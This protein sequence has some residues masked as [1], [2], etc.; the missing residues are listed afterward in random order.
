MILRN[1]SKRKPSNQ[2]Q[3]PR[4]RCHR[5]R[6][7]AVNVPNVPSSSMKTL[8]LTFLVAGLTPTSLPTAHAA[9]TIISNSDRQLASKPAAFGMEFEYGLQYVA[10]LQV[11]EE[12]LHLCHGIRDVEDVDGDGG[13]GGGYYYGYDE[14]G[15]KNSRLDGVNYLNL[16]LNL[17]LESNPDGG[18]DYVEGGEPEQRQQAER[19]SVSMEWNVLDGD[20]DNRGYAHSANRTNGDDNKN[21]DNQIYHH[22]GG[23]GILDKLHSL[24]EKIS[25]FPLGR[26]LYISILKRG[27]PRIVQL[28]LHTL[29]GNH[30]SERSDGT[31]DQPAGGVRG[32]EVKEN[33]FRNNGIQPVRSL[34]HHHRGRVPFRKQGADDTNDADDQ[35]K[36]NED[37]DDDSNIE[38]VPSHGVPVALLAKRGQCTYETKARVASQMTSPHGVVRFVIVYDNDMQDGHHLITMMPK[39]NIDADGR[40]RKGHDLWKDIGLVF[41]SYDSGI[42]LHDLI[43]VQSPESREGGGPRILIDGNE[44]WFPS[45]TEPAAGLAL[46][47]MLFGCVCSLSLLLSTSALGRG[48]SEEAA[49]EHNLFLLGP[50]GQVINDAEAQRRGRHRGGTGRRRGNGLRLLTMDEVETLPTMEYTSPRSSP[51]SSS[52]ELRDKSDMPY[53]ADDD[54]DCDEERDGRNDDAVGNTACRDDD[55]HDEQHSPRGAGGLCQQLLEKFH[56]HNSCSICLDEYEPGEQIRVLPCGHTFHSQCIFPW[57]TERSPTCPLCKAMFEAVRCELDDDGDEVESGQQDTS[58][59][60]I[61]NINNGE[62]AQNPTG[63]A[64]QATT[65]TE[66]SADGVPSLEES[67]TTSPRTFMQRRRSRRRNRTSRRSNGSSN[68]DNG[69]GNGNVN[70]N[71]ENDDSSN[72]NNNNHRSNNENNGDIQSATASNGNNTTTDPSDTRQRS[73]WNTRTERLWNFFGV[74]SS[75][76]PE[77]PLEEPLL[78]VNEENDVV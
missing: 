9:I 42:D 26:W 71:T 15:G 66:E 62:T 29:D 20:D 69:N 73:W 21:T 64:E 36:G 63:N 38:I 32:K 59:N 57:L 33:S 30:H 17:K 12:D 76:V 78:P 35:D 48:S 3:R 40:T 16:N 13:D 4:H 45:Y 5:R 25:K 56:H 18:A 54:D 72:N 27:R 68:D 50:D 70:G 28:P 34:Q 49:N 46:L 55:T 58:R 11:V 8:I 14:M 37:E 77:T 24:G 10:K 65:Q 67:N 43:N 22:S 75:E 39:D 47:L 2:L 7:L 51:P 19:N 41:V 74:P 44:S 53:L 23:K 1:E 31:N 6:R 61:N 60:N 52:L